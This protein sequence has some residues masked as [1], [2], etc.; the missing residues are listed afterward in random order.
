[1]NRLIRSSNFWNAVVCS[2]FV[3]VAHSLTNGDQL[4]TTGIFSLFGLRTLATGSADL[5]NAVKK[6][7]SEEGKT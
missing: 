2:I 1:M 6:N 3:V 5:V 4:V 7:P